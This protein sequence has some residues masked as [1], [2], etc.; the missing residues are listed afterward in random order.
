MNLRFLQAAAANFAGEYLA[1][2]EVVL[3]SHLRFL[4]SFFSLTA[5]LLSLTVGRRCSTGGHLHGA[6]SP[7][8]VLAAGGEG[9]GRV[10]LGLG[11]PIWAF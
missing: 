11:F 4:P 2:V 9:K 8:E 10:K 1:V 5:S 3:P 7:L 6:L